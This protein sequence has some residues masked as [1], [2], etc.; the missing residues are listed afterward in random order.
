MTIVYERDLRI[1]GE[2]SWINREAVASIEQE[3]WREAERRAYRSAEETREC[4]ELGARVDCNEDWKMSDRVAFQKRLIDELSP[5]IYS[6]SASQ[7][8]ATNRESRNL[9][10][11]VTFVAAMFLVLR[12]RQRV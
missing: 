9:W 6:E 12:W 10:A 5:S 1:S 7:F 3:K 11:I 2:N 4:L 8:R